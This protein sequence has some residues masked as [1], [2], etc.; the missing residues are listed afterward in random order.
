M[1]GFVDG[2]DAHEQIHHEL[3]HHA[4]AVLRNIFKNFFALSVVVLFSS[5]EVNRDHD[6]HLPFTPMSKR[7]HNSLCS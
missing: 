4:R 7:S 3:R 2:D 5:S 6:A 1:K